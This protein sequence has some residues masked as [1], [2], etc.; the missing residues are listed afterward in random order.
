MNN[1]NQEIDPI[2]NRDDL[3]VNHTITAACVSGKTV[4]YRFADSKTWVTFDN[5]NCDPLFGPWCYAKGYVW[6]V[7]PEV[8]KYRVALDNYGNLFVVTNEE[9][10]IVAEEMPSFYKWLGDW[11]EYDINN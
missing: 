2:D 4:Q 11:V 1:S 6:R 3:F 10:M 8:R 7:K 5:K 9:S